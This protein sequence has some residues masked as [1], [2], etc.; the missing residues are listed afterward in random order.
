M[1]LKAGDLIHPARLA[2]SGRTNTPGLFE[3][4]ELMGRQTCIQRVES[5]IRYVQSINQ[6]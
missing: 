4:M 6:S 2:I 3:V 5:A 1:G